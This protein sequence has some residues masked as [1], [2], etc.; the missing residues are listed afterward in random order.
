MSRKRNPIGSPR[1]WREGRAQRVAPEQ[2][3][4]LTHD[5]AT[6]IAER[7]AS[8]AREADIATSELAAAIGVSQS[9][10]VKW[11]SGSETPSLWRLL[12]IA[13]AMR[14]SLFDLLP[15]GVP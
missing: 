7:L 8:R 14:C 13:V 2:L 11:I 10:V 1:R 4:Q 3:S 6:G 15:N 5:L 9:M 12:T